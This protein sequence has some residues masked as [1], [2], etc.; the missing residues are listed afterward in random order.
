[1]KVSAFLEEIKAV[2]CDKEVVKLNDEILELLFGEKF[3]IPQLGKQS[4]KLLLYLDGHMQKY[5]WDIEK[6]IRVLYTLR[7][8]L[9]LWFGNKAPLDFDIKFNKKGIK[10]NNKGA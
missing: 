10:I 3:F 7:V 1:M 6:L 9:N 8:N 4:S 2:K 5:K